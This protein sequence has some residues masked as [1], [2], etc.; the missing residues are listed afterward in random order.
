M[1]IPASVQRKH[2]L[3]RPYLDSVSARV[4]DIVRGYCD[5]Q[6]YA[7]LGRVKE[8]Q[9][10]AEKIETGRYSSWGELDDLFACAIIVPAISDEIEVLK[11]LRSSFLEVEC[12]LRG[13]ARKDPAVFRFD[14]TRFI[15]VLDPSVLPC[16]GEDILGVKFEIQ[17][18]TAFEHA[19]SVTTHAVAYKSE[20]VD[21]R[22]MRLAAQLKATVE[23]LDQLVLGFEQSVVFISE[24]GWPKVDVLKQIHFAF[25]KSLAAGLLPSEV[26][27]SSWS[28]FC[29][30]LYSFLRSVCP[31][32][33][34]D[35]FGAFVGRS[36]KSIELEVIKCG[37]GRFPRS[38]SLLQFC[39][40]VLAREGI[41]SRVPN[42]YVPLVTE[43]LLD[44]Y[45]EACVLGKGFNF[46]F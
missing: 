30:N 25:E 6:G 23:Q 34:D 41:V 35:Q 18:R 16:A 4:R 32:G 46:E 10:L 7:Y 20:R 44:M 36:I 12:R 26:V 33:G 1:I 21:W 40:G 38:I 17:I 42:K 43:E 29:E 28:R 14:A 37:G 15:G 27:P 31:K 19:W 3:V 8:T 11:V 5:S 24:Q 13:G 45:P 2:D 22:Y 9:S 39:Q